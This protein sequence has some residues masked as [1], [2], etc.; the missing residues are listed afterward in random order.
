MAILFRRR[1]FS[2]QSI[3]FLNGL[4]A[5]GSSEAFV[6]FD[7]GPLLVTNET[8]PVSLVLVVEGETSW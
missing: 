4:G 2:K 5:F 3:G 7:A 8:E 1:G 6:V